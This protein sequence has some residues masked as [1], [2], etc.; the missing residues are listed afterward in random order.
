MELAICVVR[1]VVQ[2]IELFEGGPQSLGK[3]LMKVL[4]TFVGFIYVG[5]VGII[6][7][8]FE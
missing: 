4:L 8:D 3:W 7:P 1:S 6:A 2:P 5:Y